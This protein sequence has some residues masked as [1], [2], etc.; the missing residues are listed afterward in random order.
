MGLEVK[1]RLDQE[2]RKQFDHV[3]KRRGIVADSE[4]LRVL[5]TD[6]YRRVGV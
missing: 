3:K 1:V 6:E 4:A 5:I 2:L